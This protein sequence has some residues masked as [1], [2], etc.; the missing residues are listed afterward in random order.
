M[1]WS[2]KGHISTG[3]FNEGGGG[4]GGNRPTVSI[5]CKQDG[6]LSVRG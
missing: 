3:N 6:E 5:N 2:N 1:S 4:A